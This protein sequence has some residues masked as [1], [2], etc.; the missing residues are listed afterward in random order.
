MECNLLKSHL[1]VWLCLAIKYYNL[2]YI[3]H[4]LH[5]E[6]HLL[7]NY[8]RRVSTTYLCACQ[9]LLPQLSLKQRVQTVKL[10]DAFIQMLWILIKKQ[11][12]TKWKF[13]WTTYTMVPSLSWT[14]VPP[15]LLKLADIFK[16]HDI[17]NYTLQPSG[18]DI[19]LKTK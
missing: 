12:E 3:I 9:V 18:M 4:Y 2:K 15:I 8:I 14:K 13:W 19:E 10:H 7:Y 5:S 16:G 11:H 17:P 6:T 1:S